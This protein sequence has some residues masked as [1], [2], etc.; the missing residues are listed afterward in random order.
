MRRNKRA[1]QLLSRGGAKTLKGTLRGQ[2][3]FPFRICAMASSAEPITSIETPN[4][5]TPCAQSMRMPLR[6]GFLMDHPSPHMAAFLEAVAA[7]TDCTLQVLYCA[8]SGAGRNWGSPAG[9]VPHRFE[10]GISL[11]LGIRFNP[12]ILRTMLR[13]RADV[14]IV[15]TV[16]G[17][18]TTWMAVW[19]LKRRRIPCAFMNEPVRPRRGLYALLKE[20][21][22]RFV[23]RRIDGILA[24]GKAALAMYRRRIRDSRP[25]ES[26]PY[27]VDLSDFA[28]LPN[29]EIPGDGGDVEFVTSCQMIP[30][31][32]VDCLLKACRALPESGWHLTLVGDGPLKSK[33]EKEFASYGLQGKVSFSGA[34]PYSKRAEAFAGK[35]C[36]VLPSRWDG[37]GMVVPEALASGLP[38]ISTDRVMSAQE[39]IRN[40][41]NGFLV[42]AG[43][44]GALA[45]KMLWFL[46]NASSCSR[47]SAAARKSI[48]GYTAEIGAETLIQF[49][50]KLRAGMIQKRGQ[51]N[52]DCLRPEETSWRRLAEP[53]RPLERDLQRMRGFGKDAVI[54]GRAALRRPRKPGGHSILAYHLILKEDCGRF[55]EHIK[56]FKD[57]F[58]IRPPRDLLA[59]AAS[60]NSDPFALALT[61]DDGFRILM[62]HC[63]EILQKYEIKAGFYIPAAFVCSSGR[64]RA[65][66]EF[67]MRSFYYNFPLEPMSPE[68]LRK[69]ADLGHEIG[70]HG[71]FHTSLRAMTP[72]SAQKQIAFSRSMISEWTGTTLSGFSYPYGEFSN[73]MGDPAEWLRE[74][75]FVYALTM[76]R[77][78]VEAS[79]PPYLLPRHHAEGNWPVRHLRHF[80]MN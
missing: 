7:R 56:F 61:F 35:H 47:M 1:R 20:I 69:L 6:V 80:L 19:W 27:F 57:H 5:E 79:S 12:G 48:R 78:C 23:L 8:K 34:I 18:L 4:T 68:D 21:P 33:L 70:S 60:G 11:P 73:S 72:D 16:Y 46:K 59:A 44:A 53:E 36:F 74:A 17:S 32:G 58:R 42:P 63:L 55:E 76:R 31:K 22:L 62:Q 71:F 9:S 13:L 64:T 40:G 45:E 2:I 38:V 75:G 39:F 51:G 77:G 54:R 10:N 52:R 14:W 26:V 41:E 66:A 25:V 67:S 15:N 24:T 65:A 50:V 37:W 49:L 30:R 28:L 3:F 43:D 29:P